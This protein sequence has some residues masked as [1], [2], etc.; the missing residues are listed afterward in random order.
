MILS[1][2]AP[3]EKSGHHF[4]L[5]A[6][7]I[8]LMF[9]RIQK[10][11]LKLLSNEIISL[12]VFKNDQNKKNGELQVKIDLVLANQELL[13]CLIKRLADCFQLEYENGKYISKR[14]ES[15]K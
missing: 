9:C 8:F 13:F 3:V 11:N 5:I 7:Y 14:K 4:T 10:M 2:K 1:L 15:K 6:L 12:N